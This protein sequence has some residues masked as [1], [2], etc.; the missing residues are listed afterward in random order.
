MTNLVISD[1]IVTQIPIIQNVPEEVVGQ[2]VVVWH[3]GWLKNS[4][5]VDRY[6]QFLSNG[7]FFAEINPMSITAEYEIVLK[8]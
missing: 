5:Y 4:L 3:N 2:D 6:D 8:H 1:V 7:T